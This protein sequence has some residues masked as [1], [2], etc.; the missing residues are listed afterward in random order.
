[1]LVTASQLLLAYTAD[2][3]F[4]DPLWLPHPVRL[5]GFATTTMEKACRKLAQSPGA[6]RLAGILTALAISYELEP[7]SVN[8]LGAIAATESMG[9]CAFREKALALIARERQY[10][11]EGLVKLGWL[12]P[13]PSE[14]NFLLVRIKERGVR[15]ISLRKELEARRILIR[16]CT[17]FRGL[18]QRYVRIAVRSRKENYALLEAL[19]MIG[20]TLAGQRE[21]LPCLHARS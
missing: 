12:H 13:Y 14:A 20:D 17:D 10:L 3:A 16:D 2:L 8:T 4:G 11:S 1:M 6:L 15:G 21:A 9:D 5:F 19:R 7:W 18:G